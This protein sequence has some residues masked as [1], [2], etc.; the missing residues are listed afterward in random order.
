M[1][2][3]PREY[4]KPCRHGITPRIEYEWVEIGGGGPFSN[5]IPGRAELVYDCPT[6]YECAELA[7]QDISEQP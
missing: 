4:R 1:T 3:N 5:Q 6:P 7:Y 2:Q